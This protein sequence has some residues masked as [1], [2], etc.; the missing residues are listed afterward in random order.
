MNQLRIH[1]R[2][3]DAFIALTKRL[4]V[5][6]IGHMLSSLAKIDY[7]IKTGQGRPDVAIER[8]VLAL[9]GT[10]DVIM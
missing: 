5:Q 10:C 2:N 1:P 3:R 9:A 8:M 4:T 7:A 6:Q